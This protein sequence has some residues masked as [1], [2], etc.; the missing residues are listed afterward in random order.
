[1]F[2]ILSKTIWFLIQ[3]TSFLIFLGVVGIFLL[4]TKWAYIGKIVVTVCVLGLLIL[5]LSPIS[6]VML[7]PLEERFSR[8][9]LSQMPEHIDG[10]IVLGG[11]SDTTVLKARKILALNEAGERFSET[12]LLAKRFPNAKIIF[13]GGTVAIWDKAIPEAASAGYFFREIGINPNRIILESKSRNT[14]ENALFTKEIIK[15]KAG[16]KWLLVTSAFHMTRAVGCFRQVGISVIPWPVDYRTRGDEDYTSF[17]L[18]LSDGLRQADLA[19]KEWVGLLAYWL[20]GKIPDIFP[21][22]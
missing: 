13:T 10:I 11:A 18:V 19:S 8:P 22:P 6:N 3:P 17:F 14:I 12:V 20:T 7:L 16:Q 2:F 9:D 4:W 15:P 21:A 1:M 5:G